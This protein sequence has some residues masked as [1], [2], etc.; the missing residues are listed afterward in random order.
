MLIVHIDGKN[1]GVAL[2]GYEW[3][4]PWKALLGHD[5]VFY[6]QEKDSANC[7]EC[8]KEW[9]KQFHKEGEQLNLFI[10]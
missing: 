3:K 7:L 6:N 9:N 8:I 10:P 5:I 1:S 2:C 4:P